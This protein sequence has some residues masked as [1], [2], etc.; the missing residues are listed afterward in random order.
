MTG[1]LLQL[2][3]KGNQD[4][5]LT[6][7]PEFT[8]F[9]LVYHRYT[10]FSRFNDVIVLD[11]V[12]FG[13]INKVSIP[14]NG[15]LLDNLYV[16][17]TL[18]ELNVTYENDLYEEI[19]SKIGNIKFVSKS[20]K[21]NLLYTLNNIINHL[22]K[23]QYYQVFTNFTDTTSQANAMLAGILNISNMLTTNLNEETI[24]TYYLL[25]DKLIHSHL[26]D[27]RLFLDFGYDTTIQLS[28]SE[29]ITKMN[30]DNDNVYYYID[31]ILNLFYNN[32]FSPLVNYLNY[33]RSSYTV[34][35]PNLYL[36]NLYQKVL[37]NY[38]DNNY[39]LLSYYFLSATN[40]SKDNSIIN[41]SQI[42]TLN[43]LQTDLIEI[44]FSDIAI[45]DS[46]K[47]SDYDVLFILDS[48][49]F[50]LKN[51]KT[52]LKNN[53]LISTIE[54]DVLYQLKE[55][56]TSVFYT[57]SFYL[58]N[59][60]NITNWSSTQ[61][62]YTK[63]AASLK[64]NSD[65]IYEV[66]LDNITNIE[67]GQ[68]LFGFNTSTIG[69]DPDFVVNVIN[70]NSNTNV[71][72]V[73][74]FE[75][76][77][78]AYNINKVNANKNDYNT[79]EL[80]Y[81]SNGFL[82][83]TPIE[84]EI[85]KSDI[86]NNF[87][88]INS[89][90]S[91]IINSLSKD[92]FNANVITYSKTC[93]SIQKQIL[94]NFINNLFN[95]NI[96]VSVIFN[97]DQSTKE[98]DNYYET[99]LWSTYDSFINKF[100]Y[101]S[102]ISNDYYSSDISTCPEYIY[103]KFLNK[104]V[105]YFVASKNNIKSEYNNY[106]GIIFKG[107]ESTSNLLTLNNII[108]YYKETKP[109]VT[110][111]LTNSVYND[112]TSISVNDVVYLYNTST[113]DSNNLLGVFTITEIDVNNVFKIKLTMNTY[114]NEIT[115]LEQTISKFD[116]IGDD[117]YL[118]KDNTATSYIQI[119]GN[120]TDE[121]KY[122]IYITNLTNYYLNYSSTP[123]GIITSDTIAIDNYIYLYSIDGDNFYSSAATYLG[124]AKLSIINPTSNIS[125]SSRQYIFYLDSYED[126]NINFDLDNY[127]Y[128]GFC[129]NNNSAD[130][131]KG[132][133]ISSISINGRYYSTNTIN[134]NS[135]TDDE[136]RGYKYVNILYNYYCSYLYDQ[137]L[138]N[139]QSS[140]FN[141]I[142]L[143]RLFLIS[144]KIFQIVNQ[145]SNYTQ[146]LEELVDNVKI[147][148]YSDFT[149]MFNSNTILNELLKTE[150]SNLTTSYTS[151]FKTYLNNKSYTRIINEID[152]TTTYSYDGTNLIKTES[153][154]TINSTIADSD[155]LSEL[156][157][158]QSY[159]L[160]ELSDSNYN[161]IVESQTIDKKLYY[162]AA[163]D[164]LSNIYINIINNIY[165][166]D[167]D[168]K[169]SKNIG[170]LFNEYV[171]DNASINEKI[172]R[173]VIETKVLN[174]NDVH[175]LTGKDTYISNINSRYGD[176]DSTSF[177]TIFTNFLNNES[178]I[179]NVSVLDLSENLSLSDSD[180]KS[181]IYTK[182]GLSVGTNTDFDGLIDS[183][184]SSDETDKS[185]YSLIE[186]KIHTNNE[187]YD[188]LDIN[189]FLRLLFINYIVT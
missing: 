28:Q 177:E 121:T 187:I 129:E 130:F 40:L 163:N 87:L 115:G 44:K 92:E 183:V 80:L 153:G 29:D 178:L 79:Y 126:P 145:N 32:N 9:K 53:G 127:S 98:V 41:L 139:V 33:I 108:K 155:L 20:E 85:Y 110:V 132:F 111:L 70:V 49:T 189:L 88:F 106:S 74:L 179:N 160:S 11:K 52:I 58:S 27:S 146:E 61:N 185:I 161:S 31:V 137:L 125:N 104:V 83:I 54:E 180:L 112:S 103:N 82:T 72:E 56:D 91:N 165:Y 47:V 117:A 34:N 8:F 167:L 14:K 119:N 124:K 16:S 166:D 154:S 147:T 39:N 22:D 181:L 75:N 37:E 43:L 156:V 120:F 24:N 116:S 60:L 86:I 55:N 144:N 157:L 73:T 78:N 17:V 97:V 62:I 89:S 113:I 51:I 100:L 71:I 12:L 133:K 186:T 152:I 42:D 138:E 65:Y 184:F 135:I 19:N 95:D 141:K 59:Y 101:K 99:T 23:K 136:S 46:N 151:K 18:P 13:S 26:S 102:S 96:Y 159:K 107:L 90:S 48:T 36:E 69:T 25:T 94:L 148:Y 123:S 30:F 142:I 169:K 21:A 128:F 66:T 57:G 10:N 174:Y 109:Y 158:Y 149:K 63:T 172:I 171:N 84:Y 150:E 2:I 170:Y 6:K 5:L 35:T 15:D 162:I 45:S 188:Y 1:G 67:S 118:F 64:T 3:T 168:D 114:D 131:T 143:R 164:Y 173:T 105:N 175:N 134:T 81:L 50:N 140:E 176:S 77:M 122:T 68:I 7:N 38:T 93:L 182:L 4:I 76:K